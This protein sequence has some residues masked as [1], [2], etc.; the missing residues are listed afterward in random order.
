M[1]LPASQK[2]SRRLLMLAKA[3]L[4]MFWRLS[5]VSMVARMPPLWPHIF[6]ASIQPT[7]S[8]EKKKQPPA[9]SWK[10]GGQVEAAEEDE[11]R[12]EAWSPRRQFCSEMDDLETG[13]GV[14][15]AGRMTLLG[16]G[17]VCSAAGEGAGSGVRDTWGRLVLVTVP[18]LQ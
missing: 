4:S 8:S 6:R 17:A 3:S 2:S 14:E 12:Q 9:L 16:G 1:S 7:R 18:M 10:P 11:D 15:G 13:S 5:L